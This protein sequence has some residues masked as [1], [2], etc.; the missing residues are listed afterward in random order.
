MKTT[1]AV[2]AERASFAFRMPSDVQQSS[3]PGFFTFPPGLEA[4]TM[5]EESDIGVQGGLPVP[6][7]L[8][9]SG[10]CGWGGS[11][12]IADV[13]EDEHNTTCA[14]C[15]SCH[16]GR[17][18]PDKKQRALLKSL[19][20]REVLDIL[21]TQ[22]S[23]RAQEAGLFPFCFSTLQL[24]H[25]RLGSAEGDSGVSRA[26]YRNL[27]KAMS[28]MSCQQMIYLIQKNPNVNT[29]FLNQLKKQVRGM[30]DSISTDWGTSFWM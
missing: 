25:E 16:T 9:L 2:N 19:S 13:E 10:D 22:L 6:G 14:F 28:K 27:E 8:E 26:A 21:L 7:C 29:A 4:H 11:E 1:M 3:L 24:I 30:P 15:R 18:K 23:L 12:I 20:E 17:V 5:S